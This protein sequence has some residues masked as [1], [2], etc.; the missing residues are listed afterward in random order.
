[1]ERRIVRHAPTDRP[2]NEDVPA[3]HPVPAPSV[4]LA[5]S[6]DANGQATFRDP[7]WRSVF[8]DEDD[9]WARVGK[10]ERAFVADALAEAA[11]GHVVTHQLVGLTVLERDEPLYVL[12]HLVPV[13]LATAGAGAT[14]SAR[15]VA[16]S[17]TAEMLAEPTS[18]THAWTRRNRFELVGRL[19]TG[20]VHDLN[21]LLASI[22][23]HLELV[24]AQESL[25]DDARVHWDTIDR[26]ALD[27]ARLIA[28]IQRFLRREKE[29]SRE[30]VDLAE[31]ARDA[32]AFT[33]PYWQNEARRHDVDIRLMED[34]RPVDPIVGASSELREVLVNLILNA[35]QAMPDGGTLIV[36]TWQDREGVFVAVSDTGV[37][38]R[39]EV[40]ARIFEPM[41]TTK[42][43]AGNG[44]GLA[45]AASIVQAHHGTIQ[46]D[47]TPGAGTV[48]RLHFPRPH[49][50]PPPASAPGEASVQVLVVDDEPRVGEVL[51][52]LLR[53]RG[54]DVH[55]VESGAAA[56]DVAAREPVDVVVTDYGMPEMTGRDLA[57][58]LRAR[59]PDLP[60]LLLSGDTE[61]GAD[62][63]NIDAVL[64]KP[65][66]ADDV[67]AA[68]RRLV[69]PPSDGASRLS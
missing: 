13:Y 62:D 18:F 57:A 66:K 29:E 67:V 44:M 32:A 14:G 9:V 54:F 52:R 5:A 19:T 17:A 23:G 16:L 46:V 10:D 21:N 12:L 36:R 60:I 11:Q 8:G 4:L 68:L 1:M 39:P 58:A 2:M 63:P 56:L 43:E 26:A 37:G 48:F 53:L 64:A 55:V 47:S 27:G 33:R 61:A 45:V 3:I 15:P 41:F 6:F 69:A 30:P 65:F 38:M 42:G 59:H 7:G 22:L 35:T 25:S 34:L 28:K 40:Q 50:D 24:R 49:L 51:R 20:V 31:V